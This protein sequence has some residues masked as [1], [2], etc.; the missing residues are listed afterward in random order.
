MG[1]EN[2]RVLASNL[3]LVW[4]I[5]LHLLLAFLWQLASQCQAY[6]FFQIYT[7]EKHSY[8]FTLKIFK[9]LIEQKKSNVFAYLW[10][11]YYMVGWESFNRKNLENYVSVR[12]HL[13]QV[14][15]KEVHL[16]HI[17]SILLPKVIEFSNSSS[18]TKNINSK[19]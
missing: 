16:A 11:Q 7:F 2:L 4:A 6:P 14:F 9:N 10:R 3:S 13:L 19:Y 18:I 12:L 1:S 5:C 15:H 8:H 17:R